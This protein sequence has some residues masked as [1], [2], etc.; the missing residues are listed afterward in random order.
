[1][2][3]LNR[4]TDAFFWKLGRDTP[5]WHELFGFVGFLGS[6]VVLGLVLLAVVGIVLLRR[7]WLSAARIGG[8]AVVGF[9]VI[10]GLNWLIGAPRP[11]GLA[12]QGTSGDSFASP[13]AFLASLTFFLLAVVVGARLR[14]RR[15]S[16]AVAAVCLVW[17]LAL[18][19]FELYLRTE[20]LTAILAGWAFGVFVAL[21]TCQFGGLPV[22]GLVPGRQW[23]MD[24]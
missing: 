8:I 4:G 7:G 14:S 22:P 3:A 17:V 20:Y 1:M 16:V 9:F 24:H 12:E 21:V 2:D 5:Q 18:G 10:Q 23:T 19:F 13:S 15:T 11:S 6:P